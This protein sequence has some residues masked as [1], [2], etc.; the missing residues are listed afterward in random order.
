[1]TGVQDLWADAENAL[2]RAVAFLRKS[3]LPHGEF[4]TFVGTD[5]QLSNPLLDSSPFVTTFVVYALTH[6]DRG[7]VDDIAQKALDFLEREM[8]FGGVWRYYSSLQYKHCRIPPDLDDTACATYALRRAGRDMPDNA[9][10]FRHCTDTAG[11]FSTWITRKGLAWAPRFWLVRTVGA[12]QAERARW[13]AARPKSVIDPRL[14]KTRRDPV[15]PND[16]DPVVNANVILLFGERSE[17]AASVKYLI[18]FVR[19]GPQERFSLYYRDILALYYMVARAHRHS[20]PSL[21]AVGDKVTEEVVRRQR[22][23]GSFGAP[24]STALAASV[25]QTF[26]PLSPALANAIACI[27]GGQRDDGSWEASP[28]YCG[29]SEF[30]G[31]EELTTAFCIEALARYRD[32]GANSR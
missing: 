8:E 3:Q 24:L 17:S 31:S 13:A 25:L 2:D 11:R 27:V 28:F 18:D 19:S 16:L 12:V 22:A 14:L 20:A 15:P 6:L 10:I 29:E 7:Q 1:M 5:M 9:W 21:A 23:N 26:A 4:R 32:N 30:W